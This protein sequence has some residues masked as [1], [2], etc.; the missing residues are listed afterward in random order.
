MSTIFAG[1]TTT[2]SLVQTGDISGNLVLSS[3]GNIV[4]SPGTG[5]GVVWANNAAFSSGG[6]GGLTWAAVQTANVTA[7]VNTGYPIDTT[8]SNITVTL[9]S[10]V[11]S[12]SLIQL[13]DYAQTWA[14]KPVTVYANGL[15][16]NGNTSNVLLNYNSQSVGIVYV[17]STKGWVGYTG[18]TSTPIGPYS[19]NYLIVAGGGGG[20]G[21][22]YH[23]GGGGA[24]GLLT[25]TISVSPGTTYS[26]VVG[27]GGN[28][29]VNTAKGT[30]GSNSSALGLTCIGGGAGGNYSQA[31]GGNPGGSGG[32]GPGSGAPSLAGGSGTAGQGNPGGSGYNGAPNY[33]G[34]GGGGAGASGV[35]GSSTTGGTG[36]I[37]TQSSL[38]GSAVYYA[39][40]GGGSTYNGGT[41]GS[42]GNGG[43]GAGS[44]GNGTSA[45]VNSGGGGGGAERTAPATGGNGG[46]GIVIITYIGNQRGTGG[47]I[48]S[49]GG[50]TVHSFTSSG[51]FVA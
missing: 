5:Y 30:D 25:S 43:G 20:G 27:A 49:S 44:G 3:I 18:F 6:S 28:G 42:G 46:S 50:Y 19:V 21:G 11:A 37:G 13:V 51:T 36:G 2:T 48:T 16:I 17:D 9:P 23:G 7:V 12:G 4:L 26:V 22:Q 40:G 8:S 47:T 10:T 31:G 41:P 33:G 35:N 34:G 1:N 45:T 38:S 29:G 14:L 24:G 32:G 15:K 39:G